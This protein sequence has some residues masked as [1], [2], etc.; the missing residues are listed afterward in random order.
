MSCCADR[1]LLEA[2]CVA[3]RPVQALVELP[4]CSVLTSSTSKSAASARH[5]TQVHL[6]FVRLFSVSRSRDCRHRLA[7][8]R[9]GRTNSAGPRHNL[10][11]LEGEQGNR[12]RIGDVHRQNIVE[13]RVTTAMHRCV[14]HVH[15]CNT[16]IR[17]GCLPW[18]RECTVPTLRRTMVHRACTS[19]VFGVTAMFGCARGIPDGRVGWLVASATAMH[20]ALRA[21]PAP[22][23]W[24]SPS[25]PMC[26]NARRCR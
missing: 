15:R 2:T 17:S 16:A 9:V 26:D 8:S 4:L 14:E 25:T 5:D 6:R 1:H 18:S 20:R 11:D 21:R 24:P 7:S 13:H 3:T 12:I 22:V 19:D 10:A 23:Y